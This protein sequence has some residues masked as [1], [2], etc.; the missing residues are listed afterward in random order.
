MLD[1][2]R[3]EEKKKQTCIKN[4][5]QTGKRRPNMCKSTHIYSETD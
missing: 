2:D 4:K 3:S 5:P 1:L